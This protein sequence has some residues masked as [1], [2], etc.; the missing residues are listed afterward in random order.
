MRD[1][2]QEAI[3]RARDARRVDAGVIER[4]KQS[5][6]ERL[7][8][9][10]TP[11]ADASV[12]PSG[13]DWRAWGLGAGVA[14]AFLGAGI[15]AANA[16]NLRGIFLASEGAGTSLSASAWPLQVSSAQGTLGAS[17]SREAPIALPGPDPVGASK[18]VDVFE[19]PDGVSPPIRVAKGGV[20]SSEKSVRATTRPPPLGESL[21][22]VSG[23]TPGAAQRESDRQESTLEAEVR[24]LRDA[25][26]ALQRG[27]PGDALTLLG[28]HQS[29][30]PT[31]KLSSERDLERIIVLCV[32]DPARARTEARRF[33]REHAG[34]SHLGR[35]RT[36]CAGSPRAKGGGAP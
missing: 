35:L 20:A 3:G 31:G 14:T 8:G 34:S 32:L 29:I 6:M 5:L 15:L 18:A 24:L 36:T 2:L 10:A 7:G 19:L 1:V 9:A 22:Q 33:E 27:R 4:A 30:Y 17:V 21:G 23:S 28:Q 12:R 25:D 26:A 11:S 16:G 13:M